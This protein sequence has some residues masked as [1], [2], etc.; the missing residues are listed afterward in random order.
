MIKPE[1]GEAFEH[2]FR[3]SQADVI[4]FSG[5]T[6]DRNPIHLDDAYA[7]TTQFKKPIMHGFLSA[8]IFSKVFGTIFPGEGTIYLSQN[9]IFKRPMFVD[10]VYHAKFLISSVDFEKSIFHIQSKVLD[11]SDKVCL[12]GYAS[13][14]NKRFFS[15]G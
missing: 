13:L 2:E 9:L 11:S 10:Q 14:L 5:V 15:I 7:A 6:G 4:L 3:F 1:V 8:S 12:D